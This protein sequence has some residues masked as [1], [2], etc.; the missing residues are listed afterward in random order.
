[1]DIWIS[2]CNKTVRCA[3]CT[4]DITIGS[5]MVF[6]KLWLRKSGEGTEVVRWVKNFRWHAN[7]TKDNQCCWLAQGLENFASRPYVEKRGRKKMLLPPEDRAIRLAILR[8]RARLVQQLKSLMDSEF[9]NND[10]DSF[11][12]IGSKIESLKADIE[13][14][15]GI[16]PSWT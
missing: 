10:L 2:R 16:P 5:P 6:G 1:M 7:R 8:R 11:I 9:N 3:Y 4:E 14:Y 12:S 13:P 15:G